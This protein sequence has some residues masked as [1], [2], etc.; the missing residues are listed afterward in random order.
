MIKI[1]KYLKKQDWTF[2]LFSIIF[3]VIQVWLGLK[4]PEYISEITKLVQTEGSNIN[5]ILRAGV[6]MLLCAL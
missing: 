6:Y 3:I 2:M 1:F 5:D 4:L